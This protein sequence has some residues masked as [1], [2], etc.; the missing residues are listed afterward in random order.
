MRNI[1]LMAMHSPDDY[2]VSLEYLDSK[3]AV[4]RRVVSPIRFLSGGRL[5]GLCLCREEPRQFYL[6]RC[7]NVK[8]C[9]AADFVMPVPVTVIPPLPIAAAG[10]PIGDVALSL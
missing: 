4:T 3:G 2:V 7:R 10:V 8:L 9:R 1:L 6:D 5:L